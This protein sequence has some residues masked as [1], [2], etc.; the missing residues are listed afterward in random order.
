MQNPSHIYTTAGS[1]HI[2]LTVTNEAGSDTEIKSN[3]IA[4]T[5]GGSGNETGTFTDARDNHEYK[6]IKIGNQVWMAENLAATKYNDGTSIPLVTDNAVWKA[7][8]DNNTDDAYCWYNNYSSSSWGALYTYAAALNTCPDGWHLPSDVEWSNLTNFIA[9]DGHLGTEGSALKA[10]SHWYNHGNITDSYGFSALPGGLRQRIFETFSGGGNNGYW[11]SSTEYDSSYAYSRGLNYRRNGV[12]RGH[13][14]KSSG[15]SVR[16]VR[17]DAGIIAPVADFTA[18]ETEITIGDTIQFTDLSSNEPTEWL[19]NF[20]DGGTSNL[21]NPSHIYTAAGSYHITLTATNAAGSDT[22]IKS[23]YIVVTEGGSGNETGT[24]IDARDNHEY[25][26]VK[27][28]NQVWMAENLAATEYNDGTAIPLVTDNSIWA[29][30]GDNNTDDAYCYY[31]NNANGEKDI[32]GALYTYAATLNA[33]PA[34]WHLPSD[35]EWTDLTNYIASDGYTETEGT[36]LKATSGWDNN[37]NGTD[38]YGFSALPGGCRYD[39]NGTFGDA[40]YY[41]FWW[42]STEYGSSSA[43]YR[44]LS[45][46]DAGVLR[47]RNGKSNGFSV[48]CVRDD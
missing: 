47:I 19:W 18:S 21:H 40:G 4:V 1:Y 28:G 7:L 46:Y 15:L 3:Y 20:N 25:K 29:A 43:Y 23:N 36:A 9:S 8:G 5:E 37:G 13:H 31:N 30:L 48:R 24:F 17:G 41:G 11:W 22:E 27:I 42:S 2:T 38:N 10:T 32:Y 26:W 35:V 33:C 12:D 16:C 6:W 39:R 14:Y 44:Y 34:G 45:Y